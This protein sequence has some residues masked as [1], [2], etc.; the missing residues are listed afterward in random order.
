MFVTLLDYQNDEYQFE[1][2][3][4]IEE[5]QATVWISVIYGDEI[6]SITYPDGTVL[7][8][9]TNAPIDSYQWSDRAGFDGAYII[10]DG[11]KN[12]MDDPNWVNRR[13]SYEFLY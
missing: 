5:K 3:D 10:Y 13:D 9:R 2:P 4:D 12:L 6:V 8:G 1:I 11:F 7:E